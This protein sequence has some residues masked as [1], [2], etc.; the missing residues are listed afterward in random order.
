MTEDPVRILFVDGMPKS[1]RALDAAAHVV[2]LSELPEYVR[3][4]GASW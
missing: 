4:L 1:A 2:T 3:A